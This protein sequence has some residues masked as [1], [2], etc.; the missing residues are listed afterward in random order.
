VRTSVCL[1]GS[2][3]KAAANGRV[4]ASRA[5]VL[6]VSE[7]EWQTQVVRLARLLGWRHFHPFNS[8]RSP[9]GFPDLC[10]V[11][12]R[13]VFAEL[14]TERGKPSAEQAHWIEALE[15][16]GAEVYVWRPSDLE[17]VGRVLGRRA[18]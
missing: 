10:L 17:Q 11:R 3:P 5:P 15:A 7:Q 16:A 9:S 18:A 6:D 8:R 13:V 14:K 2:S 4:R 1:T 12:D